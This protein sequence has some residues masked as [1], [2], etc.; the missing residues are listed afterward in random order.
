[1]NARIKG[2]LVAEKVAEK[3]VEK[4]KA[5]VKVGG[6]NKHEDE[7]EWIDEDAEIGMVDIEEGGKSVE[8]LVDKDS[9]K[10]AVRAGETPAVEVDKGILWKPDVRLRGTK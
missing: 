7:E 8:A 3:V 10:V 4:G 6:E 2:A 1:M 9:A 5:E